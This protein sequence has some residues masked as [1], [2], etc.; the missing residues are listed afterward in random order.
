VKSWV[1]EKIEHAGI[2]CWI[3]QDREDGTN[4]FKSYKSLV[5]GS[6]RVGKAAPSIAP[7]QLICLSTEKF[8]LSPKEDEK[9]D[10]QAFNSPRGHT[11][12]N[13]STLSPRLPVLAR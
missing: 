8:R 10:L 6:E 2:V 12:A 3:G 11:T 5:A 13:F 7:S 1:I 4:G 9:N